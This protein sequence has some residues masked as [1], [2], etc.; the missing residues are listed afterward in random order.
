V[1]EFSGYLIHSILIDFW[2]IA[3]WAVYNMYKNQ[4]YRNLPLQ[5]SSNTIKLVVVLCVNLIFI[6]LLI[7]L[8]LL[9]T[10][11]A[12]MVVELMLVGFGA[13]VIYGVIY[14]C[15]TWF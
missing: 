1:F 4:P 9:Y 14:S 8:E 2:V 7:G 12:I 6:G 5:Y 3:Q 10:T 13:S 11:L 15:E